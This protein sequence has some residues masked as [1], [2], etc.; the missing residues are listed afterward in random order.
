[1]LESDEAPV[2]AAVRRQQSDP[3]ALNVPYRPTMAIRWFLS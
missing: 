3:Y 2:I 1:M